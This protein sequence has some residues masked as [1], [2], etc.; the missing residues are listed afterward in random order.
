MT[1]SSDSPSAT[2]SKA[3]TARRPKARWL[4]LAV[5][6]VLLIA[7]AI[8]YG[9]RRHL[10]REALVGWLQARGVEAD[11]SF[12]SLGPRGLVGQLRIGPAASPIVTAARAEVSY[13]L[14][15][16]WRGEA[17]GVEV[18][19]IRLLQPDIRI[20]LTETGVSLG[21][22]DPLIA[23]LRDRPARADTPAPEILVEDG[24]LR[25]THASGQAVIHADAH[26]SQGVLVSLSG[27]MEPTRFETDAL[28]LDIADARIGLV[29]RDGRSS[30]SF[31][32]ALTSGR[33]GETTFGRGALNLAAAAAYPD[34]EARA[35]DGPVVLVADLNAAEFAHGEIKGDRVRLNGSFRGVAQGALDRLSLRGQT[36][37][38]V[39][40]EGLSNAGANL[41]VIK[42]S[43]ASD[44]MA[45]RRG[46]GGQFTGDVRTSL[47]AED[48][49]AGD[50]AL[51]RATASLD[52]AAAYGAGGLVLN[53][54]GPM[55]G[56]GG[57][58]GLGAVTPDDFAE[59]AAIK[60][61]AADFQLAAPEV[62]LS[63]G[64]GDVRVGLAQAATLRTAS[65][66]LVRVSPRAG[67]PLYGGQG[68]ALNLATSGGG[69]P[70]IEAQV[71]SY[72]LDVG[73]LAATAGLTFATDFGPLRG[74]EGQ[75]QGRL[76]VADGRMT[77]VA[78]GCAPFQMARLE[79]GETS[80]VDIQAELCPTDQPLVVVQGGQWALDATAKAASA[81]IPFLLARASGAEADL[82]LG[83]NRAGLFVE[84]QVA[85]AK[86]SDTSAEP[87]FHPL[88]LTGVVG[89]QADAWTG[90][91]ELESG[92]YR[93]AEIGLRHSGASGA[94]GVTI[95][96]G[97]LAFTAEG[98]QPAALSPLA[99]VVGEPVEGSALFI[100][101]IDWNPGGLQ[102][103]GRLDVPSLDFKSPA[104]AVQGLNGQIEFTSLVP[105]ETAPDQVL[106][107]NTVQILAPVTGSQVTFQLLPDQ[108]TLSAGAFQV[109][110]GTVRI[111]PMSIPLDQ[112]KSWP[113][114][115]VI[116]AVQL[117]EFVE[118]TPFADR[119]DLDAV[120]SGRLPF[121]VGPDGVTFIQGKLTAISPGRL[122]IRREALTQVDATGGAASA[123]A[124][125][126]G[127]QAVP[128]AQEDHANAAVDF[129]YQAMEHL[130]F[131]LLDAEV[132]SLPGGRL[133]VLFKIRGEH[134]PPQR[135]EIRLTLGELIS[136]SFLNKELPLPSGTKVDLTLD[137]S[138]NLNELLADYA[139]A[140]DYNGSGA[141]QPPS[142]E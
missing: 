43:A 36:A 138:L 45:W 81:D 4:V 70:Q 90:A 114:E 126:L 111:A 10:A 7:L 91:L 60:R 19:R 52:G 16:P 27:R 46:E 28:K 110:G 69:L 29:T 25:V 30:L 97:T 57:W 49:R 79:T 68:G 62:R 107:A 48:V 24:V 71:A 100:G 78:S 54:S 35:I 130:A 34:L 108:L 105:L 26:M 1:R 93:V 22:L 40:G 129:A 8:A 55:A 106:K 123:S 39:S 133:G 134:S 88:D 2:G 72:R 13:R 86:V 41:G 135:Q 66:G 73:K 80:V 92:G 61:A 136:R 137:T 125:G 77:F 128:V 20:Q 23:E 117:S 109:G 104:G 102:S 38:T 94:G 141:V 37:V 89:L 85:R 5:V 120:V 74:M 118:A 99:E 84:A 139:A 58:S 63:L 96:T 18:A 21:Q 17:F 112:T 132:N 115:L 65:G 124:E 15:G 32:G 95:D 14:A 53:L 131:D 140:Q 75:A 83:T 33:L 142:P 59:L 82:R 116:E 64:G 127:D 103:R 50:L 98:L 9:A 67:A 3:A 56:A 87:R 11:A 76:N 113:G 47:E 119:V 31:V 12:E 122:A 6:A 121:V 51:R 44:N 42:A 101:A